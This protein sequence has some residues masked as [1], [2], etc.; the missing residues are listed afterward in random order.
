[1]RPRRLVVDVGT[2]RAEVFVDGRRVGQVP[3]VGEWACASG[4]AVEITLVPPA[5]VPTDYRVPCRG[6]DI[7]VRSEH[8]VVPR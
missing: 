1:M 3:Y 5:G 4:D 2:D 7:T 6:E 8:R